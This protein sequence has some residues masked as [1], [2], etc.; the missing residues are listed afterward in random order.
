MAKTND[1]ASAPA[2]VEVAEVLLVRAYVPANGPY[3]ISADDVY[4]GTD[5][6]TRIYDKIP[7]GEVV[8]LPLEEAQRAIDLG[9]ATVTSA[10]LK[11]VKK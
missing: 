1:V 2:E 9:I 3:H 8:A 4:A 6:E 5:R 11:P 7:A 10:L